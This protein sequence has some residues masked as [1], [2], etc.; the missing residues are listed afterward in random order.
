MVLFYNS[1]HGDTDTSK[2]IIAFRVLASQL[3]IIEQKKNC[4]CINCTFTFTP[5]ESSNKA[6]PLIEQHKK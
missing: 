2:N 6:Y 3:F 5:P 4:L 1:M